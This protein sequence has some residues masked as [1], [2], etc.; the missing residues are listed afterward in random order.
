MNFFCHL[1]KINNGSRNTGAA[2]PAYSLSA[3]P[4]QGNGWHP[5]SLKATRAALSESI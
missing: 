3:P 1:E 2:A 5:E 4:E